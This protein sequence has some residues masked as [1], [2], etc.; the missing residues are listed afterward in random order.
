MEIRVKNEIG[1][2]YFYNFAP[3][4]RKPMELLYKTLIIKQLGGGLNLRSKLLH[5]RYPR[6]GQ[7]ARS[8]IFLYRNYGLNGLNGYPY[9]SAARQH[10][11]FC[12]HSVK[13]VQSVVES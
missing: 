12:I 8:W 9:P 2:R 10:N 6:Q 4:N 1:K 5:I 3:S 11:Y 13:S 7:W